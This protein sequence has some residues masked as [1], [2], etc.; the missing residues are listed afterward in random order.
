M[1][2]QKQFE[3]I[4]NTFCGRAVDVR[5]TV[6][7]STANGGA[8]FIH[9]ELADQ[10]Q[11]VLKKLR[12]AAAEAGFTLRVRFNGQADARAHNTARLTAY[13]GKDKNDSYC[14]NRFKLG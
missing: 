5:E 7:K 4:V 13:I 6:Y 3:N 14:L 11:D 12:S 8:A 10:E 1:N 2:R 9:P